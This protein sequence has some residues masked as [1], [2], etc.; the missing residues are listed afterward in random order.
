MFLFSHAKIT[1]VQVDCYS[2]VLYTGIL[3]LLFLFLYWHLLHD[4]VIR[5]L[6]PIY[7]LPLLSFNIATTN[8]VFIFFSKG[9]KDILSC[10]NLSHNCQWYFVV[11]LPHNFPSNIIGF[12]IASF[13]V[14]LG[15]WPLATFSIHNWKQMLP[16]KARGKSTTYLGS[17]MLTFV[18]MGE[19]GGDLHC[20]TCTCECP[21]SQHPPPQ[22]KK[23]F[24]WHS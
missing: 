3:L 10:T 9:Q 16:I 13:V 11:F 19:M 5:Q 20:L 1:K 23:K 12:N 6:A 2:F 22:K 14:Q 15:K 4:L 8:L 18:F 7:L 17:Y 21:Y 24:T